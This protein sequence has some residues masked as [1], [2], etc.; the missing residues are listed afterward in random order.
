M[1]NTTALVELLDAGLNFIKLG[2]FRLNEGGDGAEVN[3]PPRMS[4]RVG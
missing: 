1:W 3:K 2:A 4:H